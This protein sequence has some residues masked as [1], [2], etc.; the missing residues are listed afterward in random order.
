MTP[1]PPIPSTSIPT[2]TPRHSDSPTSL[3]SVR[4]C[5]CLSVANLYPRRTL[6]ALVLL[7]LSLLLPACAEPKPTLVLLVGG[8]GLSQFGDLETTLSATCPEATIIETGGWDGFRANLKQ[9]VRDHPCQGLVLIGHSFGCKT[10]ADAAADFTS[11]DLVVMIDPAWDDITIPP[12]IFSCLW[13]QRAL[14]GPERRATIR[15]AGRP[16]IIPGDHNDICHS[17][18]L[19]SEVSRIVRDLSERKAAQ[20][21]MRNLMTPVR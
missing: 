14:D 3:S 19:I 9:I 1:S 21:R 15:N 20:Q 13:Y 4:V 12:T 16:T 8:A 5:P 10:I 2:P 18:Q 7:L 17:P 11:V 6:Q